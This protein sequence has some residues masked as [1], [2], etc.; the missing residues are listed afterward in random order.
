MLA[1]VSFAVTQMA[2]PGA[3]SQRMNYSSVRRANEQA[4]P[5]TLTGATAELRAGLPSNGRSIAVALADFDK[6]GVPDLITGYTVGAAGALTLQ[7]GSAAATN[8]TGKD[9]VA[10]TQGHTPLPFNAAATLIALPVHPDFLKAVDLNGDGAIDVIV[11]ARGDTNAYVLFGDGHGGITAPRAIATGGSIQ[12]LTAVRNLDASSLL[13]AGVCSAKNCSLRMFAA[14]GSLKRDLSLPGTLTAIETGRFNAGR[15]DDLIVLSEGNLYLVNGSATAPGRASLEKLPVTNAASIAAG[16]FVYDRRGFLQLAMLD[17]SGNVRVLARTGLDSTVPTPAEAIAKRRSDFQRGHPARTA[18]QPGSPAGLAWSSVETLTHVAPG[19]A[20]APLLLRGRLS[21]SGSDDLAILANGQFIQ[22]THTS[23]ATARERR[24]SPTLTF[25]S[26]TQPILAAALGRISPDGRLGV[27]AA[28]G[29]FHPKI[30]MPPT[31]RTFAVTTTV[32]GINTGTTCTGGAVCSLRDAIGLANADSAGD[33]VTAMDVI[34]VPAGTYPFTTAFAPANDAD[35]NLNFHYDVDTS[36]S[37]VGAGAATTIIDANH[38]DKIF[39]FNSGIVN[40]SGTFDIFL[41]GLTLTNGTNQNDYYTNATVD[42]Y[43]GIADFNTNGTSYLTVNGCVLSNGTALFG[44][45]GAIVAQDT[46]LGPGTFEL[47]NSGVVGNSSPETGGGLAIGADVTFILNASIVY[48]NL[49]DPSVNA[50]PGAFGE[51]GGIEDYGGDASDSAVTITNSTIANN[52]TNS[53]DAGG[54]YLGNGFTMSGTTVTGNTAATTGGGLVFDSEANAGAITTSTFTANTSGEG[55][56]AIYLDEDDPSTNV[57]SIHFSRLVADLGPAPTGIDVPGSGATGGSVDATDNWWGCNGPATGT[58]CDTAGFSAPSAF[59]ATPY[60]NLTLVL[61][62]T[63]PVGATT[64]TATGSLGQD[65]S[66]MVYAAADDAAYAGVGA[67]LS[68]VQFGGDT[69]N[70][71]ATTLDAHASIAAGAPTAAAGPGTAS[72]TVDGFTVSAGFTVTAADMTVSSA[73]T[74]DFHPGDTG[75]IYTLTATNNGNASSS[76][77]VTVTDTLPAG[78]TATSLGGAGWSCTLATVTCT[79]SDALAANVSYS[80][81]TL[82]VGIST[83]DIGSYTNTVTV[84]GGDEI[85]TSNDS[86]SDP[87]QVTAGAVSAFL[88][89]G[90]GPFTA[91][92]IPGSAT[93]TAVDAYGNTVTA[94]AGTVT[95][96]SSDLAATLPAAYT[97][98]PG[99]NGV[100]VFSVTLNTAGT[101]SVTVTSA[102]ITGSETGIVVA[103]AIWVLGSDTSLAILGEDGSQIVTSGLP[104]P[105]SSLG[106]IAF[107]NSGNGWTVDNATNNVVKFSAQGMLGSVPGNAAAGVNAPNALAIDGLGQV[108]VANGNN[109]VSVLTGTGAA[110]T[111]NTGYQPGTFNLPSGIVIDSAGSVW[112]TNQNGNSVTKII[113]AAAPVTTPTVAATTAATLGARP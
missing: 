6:D 2:L 97:F 104:S 12:A 39:S 53:A 42:N 16:N 93:V 79:R 108:W 58:N 14:D 99:D 26:T 89:T 7:H 30:S 22:V 32:D 9:W 111:P 63:A 45:G 8:P 106:A 10:F 55:G 23:T 81:I 34:T 74:G 44:P 69:T 95:F 72:V 29:S 38:K 21:G 84:G 24:M 41:S 64:I 75:D 4:L 83:S 37:I 27:I 13:V 25:D 109:S 85:V 47:D 88:V 50:E 78:F 31:N 33:G 60:T 15:L 103:D 105:T 40:P 80:A 35:G 107:D 77:A 90:L 46:T 82:T 20:T 36:V 57:L 52:T 66:G 94:F 110:V 43:G 102:T 62:S 68:I 18:F 86:Y 96:T 28:D 11:A 71:T 65:S 112:V 19:S 3:W 5:Q 87:T 49:A 1:A 76:G 98:Q 61:S 51:G 59:L 100:H 73:H 113:G 91:P 92:G 48:N 70:A 56:G 54:F 67:T 17:T 101:Q